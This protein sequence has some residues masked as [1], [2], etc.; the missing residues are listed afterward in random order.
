MRR[1]YI[2]LGTFFAI[3]SILFALFPLGT[4]AIIP[5]VLAIVFS[6]LAF[7]KSEIDQKKFPKWLLIISGVC[8]L[9]VIAKEVLIKDEVAVDQK[10]ENVKKENKKEA[11]K[12]LEDLEGME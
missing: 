10:F 9:I 12:E 4:L 1:T 8:L 6:F 2:I 3:L 11:E 5:I 7:S